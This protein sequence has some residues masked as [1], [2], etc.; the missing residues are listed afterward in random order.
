MLC[1]RLAFVGALVLAVDA[2]W[3]PQG[4]VHAHESPELLFRQGDANRDDFL[5]AKELEEF[6]KHDEDNYHGSEIA[7]HFGGPDKATAALDTDKDGKVSA[8]EFLEYASP[9]HGLAVA[10]DDFDEHNE[11]KDDHLTL[12]EYKNTHYGKERVI[13]GDHNGFESHFNAIDKD[14]DKKL[15]K[16][17]W[18]N[19]EAAQD[20]FT[21]M[22]Y[23]GDK[24]VDFEEFT[25]NE[26]EHY[27]GLDH[28]SEDSKKH[29]RE[30]FDQLDK[31]KDGQ[32]T[33]AE[34][35]GHIPEDHEYEKVKFDDDKPVEEDED[36][37]EDATTHSDL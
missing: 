11:N 19:S 9:A 30:A 32:L 18:L 7:K 20:P 17:E 8:N 25:R 29:S 1:L 21:H 10:E 28:D 12:E 27:H 31:N 37:E 13:D 14:G 36:A 34:D 16:K 22:D 33:R 6:Y 15:T 26:K 24:L 2:A 4:D 5:D 35:R 3:K 23:N